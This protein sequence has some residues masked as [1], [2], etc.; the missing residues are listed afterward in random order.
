MLTKLLYLFLLFAI[1]CKQ[2]DYTTGVKWLNLCPFGN[3]KKKVVDVM[4]T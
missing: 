3:Y 2:T 4:L 1:F